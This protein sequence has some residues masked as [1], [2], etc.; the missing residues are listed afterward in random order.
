M[1]MGPQD[2]KGKKYGVPVFLPDGNVNPAYLKAEAKVKA[3]FNKKNFEK[4][5]KKKQKQIAKKIYDIADYIKGRINADPR[6]P[7]DYYPG[8]GGL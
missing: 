4:F 3:D 6:L 5:E 7:K 1:S 2:F 8:K